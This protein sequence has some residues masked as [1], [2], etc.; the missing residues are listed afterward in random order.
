MSASISH[1]AASGPTLA[2]N[3]PLGDWCLLS[4]PPRMPQERGQRHRDNDHRTCRRNAGD[5]QL[6][7]RPIDIFQSTEGTS[8]DVP[9]PAPE[10]RPRPIT[11][12]P[13]TRSYV[14]R[15]LGD[16]RFANIAGQDGHGL[17]VDELRPCIAGRIPGDRDIRDPPLSE[18]DLHLDVAVAVDHIG[19]GVLHR[20][21]LGGGG[22]SSCGR[23][24]GRGDRR[25]GRQPWPCGADWI[26][27]PPVARRE[28]RKSSRHHPSRSCLVGEVGRT[29][30]RARFDPSLG[31]RR[32][33]V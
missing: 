32:A 17:A 22:R 21:P 14:E 20:R 9:P 23:P 18:G 19:A 26:H 12:G 5:C 11:Y 29:L 7:S 2:S 1:S 10:S 6:V 30:L 24:A 25:G 13:I 4:K 15:L 3:R 16:S 33:R 8:P 28:R 27:T 31:D